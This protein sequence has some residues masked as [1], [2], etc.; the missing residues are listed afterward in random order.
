[1]TDTADTTSFAELGLSP[2]LLQAV[3]D[4]GYDSPTPIQRD[5]I[6]LALKGRDL[7]GLA[8]SGTGKTA[9]FVLPT[10]QLLSG[11]PKRLRALVLVPTRELAVQVHE[12]V[13]KYGVHSGIEAA[14]V[15]GGVAIGPQERR[16]VAARCGNGNGL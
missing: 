13:K 6:P 15:Y 1:M 7:M 10:I 8:Q 2:E 11:G 3:E 16:F 9:A 12:S 4:A 5:A 14:D